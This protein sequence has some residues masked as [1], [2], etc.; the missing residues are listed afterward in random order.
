ME[1]LWDGFGSEKGG[2]QVVAGV[3]LRWSIVQR[4]YL[5]DI[6]PSTVR[7]IAPSGGELDEFGRGGGCPP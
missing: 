5:L 6:E 3:Y 4:P 1:A 7:R 2:V